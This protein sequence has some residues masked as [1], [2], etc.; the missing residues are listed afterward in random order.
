M[1]KIVTALVA[2]LEKYVYET[3]QVKDVVGV[4]IVVRTLKILYVVQTE[5][6]ISMN[7][8]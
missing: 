6:R 7:A 8:N 5:K 4:M 3:V 2:H 1:E